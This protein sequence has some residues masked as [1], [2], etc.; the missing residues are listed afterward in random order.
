MSEQQ[1]PG[2]DFLDEVLCVGFVAVYS[3]QA[4]DEVSVF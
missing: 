3:V 2:V 4:P 1:D